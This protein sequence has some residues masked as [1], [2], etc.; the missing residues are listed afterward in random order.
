MFA[1]SPIGPPCTPGAPEGRLAWCAWFVALSLAAGGCGGLT[2]HDGEGGSKSSDGAQGNEGS[3]SGDRDDRA[4][5][6]PHPSDDAPGGTAPG[7]PGGA[8]GGELCAC[9]V[10]P[11]MLVLETIDGSYEFTEPPEALLYPSFDFGCA[12]PGPA[13]VPAACD[14]RATVAAC[15]AEAGCLLLAGGSDT[16]EPQLTW[17]DSTGTSVTQVRG[18]QSEVVLE[19]NDEDLVAGYFYFSSGEVVTHVG[20]FSVCPVTVRGCE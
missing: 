9:G 1:G 17:Y 13:Y 14:R 16:G 2:T 20:K 7:T 11:A 19:V 5:G 10:S 12:A 4:F 3:E 8:G 18:G 6:Q 15:D